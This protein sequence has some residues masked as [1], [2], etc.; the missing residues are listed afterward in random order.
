M[1]KEHEPEKILVHADVHQP[2][3]GSDPLRRRLLGLHEIKRG[4]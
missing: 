4:T 1:D 2:I 3:A